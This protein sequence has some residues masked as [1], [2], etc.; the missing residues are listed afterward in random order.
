MSLQDLLDTMK[1]TLPAARQHMH[2]GMRSLLACIA[3]PDGEGEGDQQ[4]SS[5]LLGPAAYDTYQLIVRL[6][7]LMEQVRS[8]LGVGAWM[9]ILKMTEILS[10]RN[11]HALSTCCCGC[12]CICFLYVPLLS[13][14]PCARLD[15]QHSMPM[16]GR[17]RRLM[18]FVPC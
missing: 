17:M 1:A 10:A 18:T 5:K 8:Y 16:V 11:C 12:C 15:L 9:V 14:L 7:T 3:P 2:E 4:W 13:I 6:L